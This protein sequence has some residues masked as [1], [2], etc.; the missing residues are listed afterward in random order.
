MIIRYDVIIIP[1]INPAVLDRI[2]YRRGR[3][4]FLAKELP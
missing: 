3:A 1:A 4:F 2:D